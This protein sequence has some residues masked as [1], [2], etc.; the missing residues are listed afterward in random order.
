MEKWLPS[1]SIIIFFGVV[2]ITMVGLFLIFIKDNDDKSETKNTKLITSLFKQQS[3]KDLD[4]DGLKNW[5]EDLWKTDPN[6]PDTDGDGTL[7]GDEI[8]ENRNPLVKGP[9]DIFIVKDLSLDNNFGENLAKDIGENL[10]SEYLFLKNNDLLN[11]KNKEILIENIVGDKLNLIRTENNEK[12]YS[13]DDIVTTKKEDLDTLTEYS[14]ALKRV[15]SKGMKLE[16]EASILERSLNNNDPVIL[17][18]LDIS[19]K[20]YEIMGEEL[21][22]LIVPESFVENHLKA[23]NSIKNINYSVKNMKLVFENPL[24]TLSTLSLYNE[25]TKGA[26][27][28]FMDL[29]YSL[30]KKGVNMELEI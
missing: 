3:E 18:K 13:I 14:L 2:T 5:E 10:I 21:L 12:I 4:N 28:A 1:K 27:K 24:K 25:S 11:E 15:L 7:D 29:G 26:I 16:N 9:D 8:K 30:E 17:D 19:I 23:I 22:K 6:N 20:T